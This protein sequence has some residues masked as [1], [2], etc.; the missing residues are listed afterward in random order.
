MKL[1]AY[2]ACGLAA[3]IMMAPVAEAQQ[4]V[5]HRER[6]VT[7][8]RTTVVRHGGAR[9]HHLRRVCTVRYRHH[10]RIRTCRNVRY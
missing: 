5:V 3:T 9:F 8:H 1:A 6:V 4:R 10:R 7:T 2:L